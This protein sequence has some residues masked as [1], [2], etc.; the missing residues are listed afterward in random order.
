[1]SWFDYEGMKLQMLAETRRS[2]EQIDLRLAQL[3]ADRQRFER[4]AKDDER[5]NAEIARM[6]GS[7]EE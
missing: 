7:Y 5:I 4:L 3:E 6:C 1:M 2:L